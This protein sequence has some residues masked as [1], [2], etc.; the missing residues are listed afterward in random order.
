MAISCF[1]SLFRHMLGLVVVPCRSESANEVEI[2]VL[3]HEL[4]VLRRQVER[5]S[6]RP[7]DGVFWSALARLLPRRPLGGQSRSRSCGSVQSAREVARTAA[8]SDRME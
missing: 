8:V 4:A 6:C 1:Y 7:A 5:P 3:R 2:L